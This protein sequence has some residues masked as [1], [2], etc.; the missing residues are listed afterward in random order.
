MSSRSWAASGQTVC[1]LSGGPSAEAAASRKSAQGVYGALA[2]AFDVV[3]LD[4]CSDGGLELVAAPEALSDLLDGQSGQAN[5]WRTNFRRAVACANTQ[6]VFP[7]IHGQIGEDGQLQSLCDELGL[8]CVGSDAGA[9]LACYDKVR[10]KGLMETARLPIAPYV[11]VELEKFAADGG[12]AE[13]IGDGLGYPC[14]VKP[15]R[16]GSSLGL[17]RVERPAVLDAALADAFALDDVAVVERFV[18]GC[19]VEIGISDGGSPIVG[20]PVEVEY[21]GELYDFEVKYAGDLDW[22]VSECSRQLGAR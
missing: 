4:L 14:I 1:L 17:S 18:P 15:A 3:W 21:D 6:I 7:A 16:A 20:G 11:T 13:A 19:D 5:H 22:A 8:C 12:P 9:S 2:P 10:F